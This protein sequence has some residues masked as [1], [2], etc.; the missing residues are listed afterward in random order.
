[1]ERQQKDLVWKKL[2]PPVFTWKVMR[3]SSVTVTS[4]KECFIAL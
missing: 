4:F 2:A 3:N 1:M